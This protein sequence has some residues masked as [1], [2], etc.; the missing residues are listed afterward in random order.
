MPF[1]IAYVSL[2]VDDDDKEQHRSEIDY[3][4]VVGFSFWAGNFFKK[5][6]IKLFIYIINQT[7]AHKN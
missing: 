3:K 6:L 1:K 2:N 4:F 7:C 5:C